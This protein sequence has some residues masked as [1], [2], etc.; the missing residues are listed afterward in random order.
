ML[1][2]IL[3]VDFLGVGHF[4]CPWPVNGLAL[5]VEDVLFALC[6]DDRCASSRKIC[7]RK[8]HVWSTC[9]LRF[10]CP[11]LVCERN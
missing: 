7:H 11:R 4:A 8:I 5:L 6:S 10:R 1:V 3:A 2:V 9:L